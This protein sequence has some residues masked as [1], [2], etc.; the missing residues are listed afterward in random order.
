[1]NNSPENEIELLKKQLARSRKDGSLAG[2]GFAIGGISMG[3]LAQW[4][5]GSMYP[6]ARSL[7]PLIGLACVLGGALYAGLLIAISRIRDYVSWQRGAQE[8]LKQQIFPSAIHSA[9]KQ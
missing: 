7:F 3:Y 2:I 4:Y 5:F 6:H 8:R 9:D 1:M